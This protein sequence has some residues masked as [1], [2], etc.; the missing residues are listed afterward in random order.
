M[1]EWFKWNYFRHKF[2]TNLETIKDKSDSVEE[3]FK[4]IKDQIDTR[5]ESLVNQVHEMGDGLRER[6][7]VMEKEAVK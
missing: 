6:V 5:V 3:K 7:K 4:Y 2:H 1:N